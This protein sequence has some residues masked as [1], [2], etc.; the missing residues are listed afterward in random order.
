MRPHPG[1]STT[2]PSSRHKRPYMCQPP[3]EVRGPGT[4]GD[5]QCGLARAGKKTTW[6]VDTCPGRRVHVLLAAG[7]IGAPFCLDVG[8]TRGIRSLCSPSPP[9]FTLPNL[10]LV[11]PQLITECCRPGGCWE[12]GRGPC[13]CS[14]P[15]FLLYLACYWIFVMYRH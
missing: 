15:S 6:T 11:V 8:A 9:L 4:S 7:S 5:R 1:H 10:S 3:R 13:W 12:M 2:H 14:L